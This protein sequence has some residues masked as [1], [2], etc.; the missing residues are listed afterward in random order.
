MPSLALWVFVRDK[1]SQPSQRSLRWLWVGLTS[2]ELVEKVTA[3]EQASP[4]VWC[5]QIRALG[6]EPTV[7]VTANIPERSDP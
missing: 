1:T 5:Y 4:G 7:S 6:H 3:L 2:E